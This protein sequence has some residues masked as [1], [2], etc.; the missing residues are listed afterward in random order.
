MNTA[1]RMLL[2]ALWRVL[3]PLLEATL[4]ALGQWLLEQIMNRLKRWFAARKAAASEQRARAA[5]EAQKAR[6][7]GDEGAAAKADADVAAADQELLGL[8]R[9][10][11][12]M[13][14]TIEGITAELPDAVATAM[15]DAEMTLRSQKL[16]PP[17]STQARLPSVG[18]ASTSGKKPRRRSK[19]AS[20]FRPENGG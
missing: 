12:I 4:L 5:G 9:T 11:Q 15:R 10:E 7:E 14:E 18:D 2:R 16:L 6:A 19:L 20:R 3:R 13:T 17:P 8:N 1:N